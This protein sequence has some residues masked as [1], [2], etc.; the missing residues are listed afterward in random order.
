MM[1]L[2]IVGAVVIS[3]GFAAFFGAPYVPS[4][5]KFVA[6]AFDH[7]YKLDADDVVVDVGSGDG[8]VLRVASSRGARAI[9]YEIHPVLVL[10]SRWLSRRDPNVTIELANFWN[11]HLPADTTLVYAFSVSRDNRRMIRKMQQEANRLGRE[12]KLMCLGSPFATMRPIRTYEAYTLY[13]FHPLQR[14]KAQV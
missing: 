1:W 12:L 3:F 7:L 8:V 5:R 10:I 11:V 14:K 6:R 9:G 13:A 4:R 2:V